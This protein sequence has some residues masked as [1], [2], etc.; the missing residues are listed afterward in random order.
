[1]PMRP[2]WLGSS[3]GLGGDELEA[4]GTEADLLKVGVAPDG[5]APVLQVFRENVEHLDEIRA[6][7][8]RKKQG[9]VDVATALMADEE[10]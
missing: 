9:F 6:H 7:T 5:I 10:G 4:S 3:F 8:V 2:R 1:M